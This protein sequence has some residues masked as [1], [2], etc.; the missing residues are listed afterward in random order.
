MSG[1]LPDRAHFL[2]RQDTLSPIITKITPPERTA[3]EA[4]ARPIVKHITYCETHELYFLDNKHLETNQEF[5]VYLFPEELD[6]LATLFMK[7]AEVPEL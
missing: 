3:F 1:N 5:A 2:E 4:I 6:A 7:I